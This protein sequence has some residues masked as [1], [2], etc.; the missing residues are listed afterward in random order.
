MEKG[1]DVQSIK[2]PRVDARMGEAKEEDND[3]D[4]GDDQ[5]GRLVRPQQTGNHDSTQAKPARSSA[6]WACQKNK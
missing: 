2:I 5:A 1:D 3:Q 6:V 4:G